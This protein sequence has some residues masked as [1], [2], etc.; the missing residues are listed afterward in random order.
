MLHQTYNEEFWRALDTLVS[1]SNIVIDRPKGSTHPKFSNIRYELDYGY[2]ENTSSMDSA[3]IDVW[4]GSLPDSKVG[5][6]ICTVDLM[7]K[8]SEIKILIGCTDEET[9]KVYEFHNGTEY[10][11]GMLICR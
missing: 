7:K 6:V 11:K 3:G 10:M 9:Q 1:S 8:D 2:L 5:A 4:R